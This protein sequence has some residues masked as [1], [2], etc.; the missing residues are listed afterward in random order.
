MR[1]KLHLH[2]A[3][4][5]TLGERVEDVFYLTGENN[6]A[7]TDLDLCREIEETICREL[8]TRNLEDESPGNSVELLQ[9]RH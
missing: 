9:S 7:I 8:D 2:S 3:K 5:A 6:E 1:F 4:I